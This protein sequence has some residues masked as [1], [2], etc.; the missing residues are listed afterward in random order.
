M[1]RELWYLLILILCAFSGFVMG[2]ER[3]NRGKVAGV[4]TI[5]LVIA[6]AATFTF[7]SSIVD[8]NSQSRIAANVLTG[9]GFI[10]GGIMMKKGEG[11]SVRVSNLTTAAVIWLAAAIG[12]CYGYKLFLIGM[13]LT[14]FDLIICTLRDKKSKGCDEENK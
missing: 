12:M 5:C 9:I 2:R 10:G 3:H 11:D 7:L 4:G 14:I 6:G 1:E 13:G 8:I